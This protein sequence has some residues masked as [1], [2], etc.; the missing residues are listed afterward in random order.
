MDSKS[1]NDNAFIRISTGVINK[2]G[3][4]AP[5]SRYIWQKKREETKEKNERN[6]QGLKTSTHHA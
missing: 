4:K 6:K 3:V 2:G 1:Q 5:V